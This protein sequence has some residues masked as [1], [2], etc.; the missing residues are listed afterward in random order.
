[1]A[2]FP[3]QREKRHKNM[4]TLKSK[5][6]QNDPGAF[7]DLSI[8]SGRKCFGSVFE[9]KTKYNNQNNDLTN[10]GGLT[11]KVDSRNAPGSVSEFVNNINYH[12]R[13][14]PGSVFKTGSVSTLKIKHLAL[15][16]KPS[17][18]IIYIYV[19]SPNI[20]IYFQILSQ[21]PTQPNPTPNQPQRERGHVYGN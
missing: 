13:N 14:T 17:I 11:Y 4:L 15:P 5:M 8:I 9:A 10:T 7:P 2:R 21:H 20:H 18:Y 1:M 12:F 19:C 16:A 6:T 3:L